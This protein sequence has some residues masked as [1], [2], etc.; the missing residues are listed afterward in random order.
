[1]KDLSVV[2]RANENTVISYVKTL[3]PILSSSHCELIIINNE[4]D[5][6]DIKYNYTLYK[7]SGS[8]SKFKEFCF[9]SSIGKKVMIIDGNL[10]IDSNLVNDVMMHIKTSDFNNIS[11]SFRRFLSSDKPV[12][13]A[14][15]QVFIYNRGIKGFN[16]ESQIVIDDFTLLD[17]AYMEINLNRFI[18]DKSFNELYLWYKNFILKHTLDFE[19]KFFEFMEFE[20][21]KLEEVDTEA[22]EDLFIAGNENQTYCEYLT[23][24]KELVNKKMLNQ[25]FLSEKIN[26]LTSFGN[27][28]YYSWLVY[29]IIKDRK[30]LLKVIFTLDINLLKC[31]IDYLFSYNNFLEHLHDFILEINYTGT[32]EKMKFSKTNLMLIKSYIVHAS[33]LPTDPDIKNKLL[34]LFEAYLNVYEKFLDRE[35]SLPFI[36]EVFSEKNLITKFNET[37]KY[38]DQADIN[39]AVEI[40]KSLCL[41]YPSYDRVLRYYIQKIRYENSCYPFIFSI[42]MIVKD[43]EKNL[44]R[45]LSSL[46][47]LLCLPTEII[48]VDTGSADKTVEIAKGHTQN[49][50]FNKWQGSFS[51]ARNYSLS[52]G[53][54]EYVFLLDADEKIEEAEIEKIVDE[55]KTAGYKLNNTYTLKVKNYT[56]TLLK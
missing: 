25:E 23:I 3:E 16:I 33:M 34:K 42:C 8:C 9:S 13:F 55:F 28:K 52:L 26:S 39:K 38:M 15:T 49:I 6:M 45:C 44:D 20:K 53:E 12:Y 2:I 18:E 31:I 24:R 10:Q 40:L 4:I 14:D 11:Y 54:G 37:L 48:I 46:K 50:Y 21:M 51:D 35:E 32:E 36:L 19:Q 56:D 30:D 22:I 17:E 1:M 47:P 41:E 29:Y 5:R 27:A 43:E 7:F